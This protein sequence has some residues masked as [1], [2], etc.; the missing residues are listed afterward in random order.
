MAGDYQNRYDGRVYNSDFNK[1]DTNGYVGLNKSWGY[2][3]L[4]FSTFNQRLGLMARARD[5]RTGQFLKG[6]PSGDSTLSVPVTA[7]DLRGYDL[8][9]PQQ[10]INHL[11]LGTDN[12][13]IMGSNGGRH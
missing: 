3:H 2:S 1:W 13:F 6:V 4:S 5:P 7:G 9:V 11:R 12:S 10:Q 8:A